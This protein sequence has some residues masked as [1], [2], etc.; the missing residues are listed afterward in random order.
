MTRVSRFFAGFLV[1]AVLGV[2]T[3]ALWAWINK[4]Q[5]E[6][7]WPAT[8]QGFSFSP[9]QSGQDATKNELPTEKEIDSDLALLAG[10]THAVRTYAV[11]GFAGGDPGA[12]REARTE[13]RAGNVDRRGSGARRGRGAHRPRDREQA[14]Q[15]GAT[16]RRQRG[17]PSR[18]P[19]R[20]GALGH[21]RPRARQYAP[22]GQHRGTVA[23]LAAQPRARR[24]RR[25]SRR[26]LAA[27]LGG[28]AARFRRGLLHRQ[29]AAPARGLSGQ[30]DRHRRSGL[31]VG[32]P[33][34][35][36]GRGEH[37]ERGAVPAALPVARP[38]RGLRLLRD[39]SL[40]P[41]VEDLAG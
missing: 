32:R 5:D 3:V 29:D 16:D 26:A 25:L 12:G 13:R 14:P 38:G 17:H 41:A 9:Y 33:H 11:R 34:A 20:A 35:R 10:K 2:A 37:H 18:Q 30:E 22:A 31:A 27:V 7:P 6:L 28:R 23:H 1:A 4:P 19:H 8:I 21:P 15:R 36:A 39:G 24:A 40:R